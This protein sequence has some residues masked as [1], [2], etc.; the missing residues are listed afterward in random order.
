MQTLR[1]LHLKMKAREIA[2]VLGRTVAAVN[3]R[4]FMLGLEKKK[5]FGGTPKKKP[6]N[7]NLGR[8]GTRWTEAELQQLNDL[9]STTYA[10]ELA[11]QLKRSR[12]AVKQ[13]AL[14]LGITLLFKH[15]GISWTEPEIQLLRQAYATAASIPELAASMNRTTAD[16]YQKAHGLGMARGAANT[17]SKPIGSE[18][19]KHGSVMRKVADTGDKIRD[20]KRVEVIDWEALHGP[21]P[22]GW[23]LTVIRPGQPRTLDNLVLKKEDEMPLRTVHRD[24]PP[25]L[26]ELFH[27]KGQM[28]RALHR[29]EESAAATS[30]EQLPQ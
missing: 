7:P 26:K 24:A 30:N 2:E 11:K 20:W 12:K 25:E 10:C 19:R 3:T 28:K 18:R 13:K 23:I 5:V 29:R 27:L 15:G 22:A 21:I 9:H 1:Q 8:R 6:R 16:L 14:D 17:R 4:A